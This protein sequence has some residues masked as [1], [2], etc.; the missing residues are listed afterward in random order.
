VWD[1]SPRCGSRPTAW[2]LCLKSNNK[3]KEIIMNWF[4]DNWLLIFLAVVIAIAAIFS[5]ELVKY[6]EVSFGTFFPKDITRSEWGVLGDLFGGLLNPF[7]A[8]LGLIMLLVTLF[9]NQKELSLSRKEFE[10]SADAL[11]S[12]AVTLDKQRFE[13]TFFSL[14]EQHN[15]ALN[16]ITQE[17]THYDSEGKQ[18]KLDSIAESIKVKIFG[19]GLYYSLIDSYSGLHENK[20]IFL[21]HD[22]KLNQYFRILYQVLKFIASNCPGSTVY[23]KYS[24]ESLESTACASEEKLYSNIVR[25]LLSDEVY[26]LLSI[27]CSCDDK[28]DSFYKY[29]LLIERYSFLEHMPLGKGDNTNNMLLE[30]IMEHYKCN[31]FGDNYAYATRTA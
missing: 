1:A 3:H 8:L 9:Q 20:K 6:I 11:K 19:G 12:Q 17:R 25:S 28:N 16:N 31:A 2:S 18:S 30:E 7:F 13:D 14:L 22:N 4:K 27:N 5:W 15:I 21:K 24:V 10:E 26:Y 29:K 23:M